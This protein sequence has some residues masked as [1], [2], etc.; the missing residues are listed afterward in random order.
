MII[1]NKL[2]DDN[3]A[4]YSLTV[5]PIHRQIFNGL[6][7]ETFSLVVFKTFEPGRI[8]KVRNP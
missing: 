4:P 1:E 5:G 6:V 2:Q 8:G 3:E 7:L